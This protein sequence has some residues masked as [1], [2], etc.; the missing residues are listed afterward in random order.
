[1]NRKT[2]LV[3]GLLT[4]LLTAGLVFG[5]LVISNRLTGVSGD[6]PTLTLTGNT[7]GATFIGDIFHLVV[8][9]T[10]WPVNGGN[11][12]DVTFYN[13]VSTIGLVT[14]GSG[15]LASIDWTVNTASW[16]LSATANF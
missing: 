2:I 10:N 7:T 12:V 11:G 8:T 4:T 9:I 15:G 1:M 3:I 5:T 6:T 14:S 13:G 16:N